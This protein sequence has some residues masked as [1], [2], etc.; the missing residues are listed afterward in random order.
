MTFSHFWKHPLKGCAM[1]SPICLPC[2]LPQL[3]SRGRS[4]LGGGA[5]APRGAV[6]ASPPGPPP[7]AMRALSFAHRCLPQTA[8]GLVSL[9]GYKVV[10]EPLCGVT[11]GG[12]SSPAW[13]ALPGRKR[14]PPVCKLSSGNW[15]N[16][17]GERLDWHSQ[18]SQHSAEN[19]EGAVKLP[20]KGGEEDALKTR[21]APCCFVEPR[22]RANVIPF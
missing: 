7:W 4:W 6:P 3:P 16:T 18:P 5:F 13:E 2:Q 8:M 9:D 22:I 21:V 15:I 12:S 10:A 14:E 1:T 17:Y 20:H 11:G 19:K